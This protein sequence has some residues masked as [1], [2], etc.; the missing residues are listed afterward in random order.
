[1][2]NTL[3]NPMK[4]I[5]VIQYSAY[6][7]MHEETATLDEELTEWKT[8][9]A[10]HIS[11]LLYKE[12]SD[13]RFLVSLPFKPVLVFRSSDIFREFAL[14]KPK[15]KSKKSSYQG[16]IPSV[17]KFH[18]S[19]EDSKNTLAS[20]LDMSP[21]SFNY[22]YES[23]EVLVEVLNTLPTNFNLESGQEPTSFLIYK[24]VGS[25]VYKLRQQEWSFKS[26]AK[27]DVLIPDVVYVGKNMTRYDWFAHL[28]S[29]IVEKEFNKILFIVESA[30]Q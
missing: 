18:H 5:Y 10:P 11:G 22:S 23:I 4:D 1:M 27:Y 14:K 29:A 8:G 12:D 3:P 17:E 24:Y 26:Q 15:K 19:L 9:N 30:I 21:Q 13:E 7:A 16:L 25:T 28:S 20:R 6:I 2:L